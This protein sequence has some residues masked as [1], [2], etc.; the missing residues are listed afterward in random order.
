M[1]FLLVFV[2]FSI[3]NCSTDLIAVVSNSSGNC[4]TKVLLLAVVIFLVV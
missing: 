4:R 3:V 1:G 2:Y